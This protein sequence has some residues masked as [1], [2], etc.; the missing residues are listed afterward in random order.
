MLV[1]AACS[2]RERRNSYLT[3]LTGS[4]L[5][6]SQSA[7]IGPILGWWLDPCGMEP[8]ALSRDTPT[9]VA[10]FP[11]SNLTFPSTALVALTSSAKRAKR[12]KRRPVP[13]R[14]LPSQ[15]SIDVSGAC[16]TEPLFNTLPLEQIQRV[17]KFR[18]RL[19]PLPP[20][21]RDPVVGKCPLHSCRDVCFQ[22]GVSVISNWD[23]VYK[24]VPISSW[25]SSGRTSRRQGDPPHEKPEEIAQVQ[26]PC[27]RETLSAM[28]KGP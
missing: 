6:A 3:R 24:T 18:D 17:S 27:L 26:V 12:A 10:A 22:V 15:I 11:A 4:Y 14:L 28:E 13:S 1:V 9:G 16:R 21:N 23:P 2:T 8:I 20:S 25:S 5:V 19:I 7:S